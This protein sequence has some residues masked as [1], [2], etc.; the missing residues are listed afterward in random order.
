MHWAAEWKFPTLALTSEQHRVG[1]IPAMLQIQTATIRG[2]TVDSLQERLVRNVRIRAFFDFRRTLLEKN[3][4]F[5]TTVGVNP[6]IV[7]HIATRGGTR[8]RNGNSPILR[9]THHLEKS[10]PVENETGS[11]ADYIAT[12]R[13]GCVDS[14]GIEFG[15][16]TRL[17]GG[18]SRCFLCSH[19]RYSAGY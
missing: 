8:L 12:N 2:L 16:T 1:A 19:G 18:A 7:F 13:R 15:L 17:P 3:V 9:L 6:W 14:E 4:N 11:E 10:R 5:C